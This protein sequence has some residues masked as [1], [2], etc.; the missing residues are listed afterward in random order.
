MSQDYDQLLKIV[1]VGSQNVGKSCLL[2][3]YTDDLF[4]SDIQ[5][6]VGVD[7]KVKMINFENKKVKLQIY[8]T[9]GQERFRSLTCTQLDYFQCREADGIILV[10]DI[11]NSSSFDEI[12]MWM[13]DVDKYAPRRVQILLIGNKADLKNRR[14]IT[15][16]QGYQKS[17]DH[18]TQFMETSARTAENVHEL[19][20]VITKLVLQHRLQTKYSSANAPRIQQQQ[21]QEKKGCC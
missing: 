15:M 4:V 8:D 18:H 7:F 11:T 20:T 12:D 10:Y 2:L 5:N 17:I 21:K 13:N 14:K 6:T 3:R 9:A 19:F 1:I 16:E